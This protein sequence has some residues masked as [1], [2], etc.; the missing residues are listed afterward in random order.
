MK[1]Y[2]ITE[3][4]HQMLQKHIEKGDVCIDATAGN[5]RDTAFLCEQVGATGKVYAFDIQETALKN[6]EC[7]LQ[8]KGCDTQ[9]KLIL[10][11]HESM[12]NYIEERAA[13]ITFNFGYLPGGNHEIKTQA[14]TSIQAIDVGLRLLKKGGIM[15]LC[16]YGSEEMGFEERDAILSH[17]KQ[18]NS[19]YYL[20][21]VSQYYNRE[22]HPPIPAFIIRIK[23]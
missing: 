12:E 16:I 22:N 9:V 11:G 13:A 7:Y 1:S 10:A 3:F 6:T 15:S 21:I 17:L 20:V 8:N 14:A 2:Q 19:A 23:E 4:C 5:G 18:L